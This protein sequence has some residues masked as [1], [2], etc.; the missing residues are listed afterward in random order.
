MLMESECGHYSVLEN[1]ALTL[2]DVILTFR[3]IKIK[4][5]SRLDLEPTI[6]DRLLK[7]C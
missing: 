6:S 4:M 1:G 3:D 7:E 5:L 2:M